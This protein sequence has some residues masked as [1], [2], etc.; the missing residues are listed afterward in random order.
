[1]SSSTPYATSSSTFRQ[2]LIRA[3]VLLTVYTVIISL[4]R[5]LAYELRFDFIVPREFQEE[6][7]WSNAFNLAV[8]LAFLLLFGQFRA[9]L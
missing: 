4:C 3:V 5:F 9:L 8:K 2:H 1:M 7:L 6:R